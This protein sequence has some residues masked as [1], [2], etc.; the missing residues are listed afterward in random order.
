MVNFRRHLKAKGFLYS[1]QRTKITH[2]YCC[3]SSKE[4]L[5]SHELLYKDKKSSRKTDMELTKN[6]SLNTSIELP[7]CF[8]M[9]NGKKVTV[10]HC[11]VNV[12]L[13]IQLLQ[14]SVTSPLGTEVPS[15]GLSTV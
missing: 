3:S 1:F 15:G 11:D 12:L 9:S 6:C 4:N 14:D 10:R 7:V 5:Y 8:Q 2:F 13:K